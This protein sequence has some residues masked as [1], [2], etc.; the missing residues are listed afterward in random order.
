VRI[1]DHFDGPRD[2]LALYVGLVEEFGARSALNVG[3]GTGVLCRLLAARGLSVTGVDPAGASIEHATR[4]PGAS[5]VSWIVGDATT[6][7]GLGVE[8][9]TMTGNVARVC[10]ARRR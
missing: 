3:C 1:Y 9:V 7:S 5:D 8:F 10:L 6:L 2:D 4:Q